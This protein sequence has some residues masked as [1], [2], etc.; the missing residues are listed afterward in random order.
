M[1]NNM[2]K[3]VLAGSMAL[4]VGGAGLSGVCGYGRDSIGEVK[5]A[6]KDKKE[7]QK[8]EKLEE[9]A[10][11]ALS[12]SE[13]PENSETGSEKVFKEESVYI[14]ADPEGEVTETTVTEW[15]KNPGNG[16]VDDESSLSGI[17]NVKG[18]ETFKKGSG[19]DLKWKSEGR[20]I[21]YQGT[22]DGSLPVGVKISYK[23]DGK[24]ISAKEL[25]GK[26][27]KV[28][29]NIQ[30]ENHTEET[31]EL[32]KKKVKMY[33]PFTMVTAM[34]LST[35][36]Y[37]NVEVDNGKVISDGDKNIVIGLGFPGLQENLD[38]EET[39]LDIDIPDNVRITAD[40]AKASVGATVTVGS[41]EI[42]NEFNLDGID[43]FDELKESLDE[44]ED[45]AKKLKDGSKDA[46]DGAKKLED[47][48]K[49]LKKG[50]KDLKKGTKDLKKGT[51]DL[52]SGSKDLKK[53][54]KDLK[55][56]TKNLKKGSKDLKEG[57]EELKSGAN[58][59]AGGSKQVAD[60]VSTLNKKSG[61]LIKGVNSLVDGVNTYTSGVSSLADGSKQVAGGAK[62]VN[63][64][65]DILAKKVGAL[66]EELKP[67][68]SAASAVDSQTG[69]TNQQINAAGK[70]LD[71]VD[72]D[73]EYTGDTKGKVVATKSASAI[74]SENV[75]SVSINVDLSGVPEE[76]RGEIKAAI[77]KAEAD[78]NSKLK[79]QAEKIAE[80]AIS[81]TAV[82]I[83][84]ERKAKA[85][86]NTSQAEAALNKAQAKAGTADDS[87]AQLAGL[88]AKL[89]PALA[90]LQQGVNELAAGTS[91]VS[92]G[93][94]TLAKGAEELNSKSSLLTSGTKELEKGGTELVKGVKELDKGASAV[95]DGAGEL[96][97]GAGK[98]DD[99]AGKL[100]DGAAKLDDGAGKLDDGTGKLNDGAGKLDD[101]AAKL[102]D[103]AG[104]LD[105]GA[106]KLNDGAGAL[107]DG[108]LEL[109]DGMSEFKEEGIDKLT[110][111]FDGNFQNVKDRLDAMSDMSKAY[112]SYAG[113][114]KGMDGKTK[115]IIE[116]E[117][118]EEE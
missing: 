13:A 20:D 104:K 91:E 45:A 34:M 115:F 12:G 95:A 40:V 105:N 43:S 89:K 26:S 32:N 4:A 116:T 64:G 23:L 41:A 65:A 84:Q 113:I 37:T 25:Q 76:Y 29:I 87:A 6:D 1:N 118:M 57:T 74:A 22:S 106:G 110:E 11:G 2:K 38:L 98:L 35:D 81:S 82:E 117:G 62:Q 52:E 51:K 109:S 63:D 8:I 73:V 9:T 49:D 93:A 59:L 60:G 92:T 77:E 80:K 42:M 53:G 114:K 107:S 14:K 79:A 54:T 83:T 5:A 97:K 85:V 44:L 69:K 66:T 33:T 48:S 72:A 30:Y 78:A 46:A 102:D 67:I 15:L 3:R 7:E 36:E 21:Y 71:K 86:V 55:S 28:E 88:L 58:D 100:N 50:T 75:G 111:T 17:K 18:E 61:S 19:R 56:G 47:G 39:D 90:E 103:G 99:G 112:K 70:A 31:V 68:L 101:G 16:E 24:N 10:D 108:T 96:K 94:S 27:G